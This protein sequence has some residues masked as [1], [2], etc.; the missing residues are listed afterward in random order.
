[1]S[2]AEIGRILGI[3]EQAVCPINSML[4]EEGKVTIRSVERI[5]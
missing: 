1:M 2:P 3:S 4:A 5:V